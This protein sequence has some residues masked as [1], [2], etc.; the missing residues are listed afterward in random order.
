MSGFVVWFTGLSGAGKSSL[1]DELLRRYLL[2]FSDKHA[3]V[4][5][6]DP[7]RRRTGGALLGDRIR[8]NAIYGEHAER[9]YMRSFATRQAHRATSQALR[10]SIDVCRAAA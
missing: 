6:I 2:D 5:S 7:T 3:A 9:V 10:E 4:I 8:M 1:T